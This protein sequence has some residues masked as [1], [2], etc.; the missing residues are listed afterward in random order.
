M[1]ELNGANG[2]SD[3]NGSSTSDAHAE[4]DSELGDQTRPLTHRQSM[5]WTG[6]ALDP[7]VPLYNMAHAFTID[8]ELDIDAFNQAFAALVDGSDALRTVIES[9]AG[10]PVQRVLP[11]TQPE[12]P[13]ID[14]RSSEDSE[15]VVNEWVE[16]RAQLRFDLAAKLYDSVL[17]RTG[18]A[19]YVWYLN[20]HHIVTDAWSVSLMLRRQ[21]ELYEL[22]LDGR[23]A[24]ADPQSAYADFLQAEV[25]DIGSKGHKRAL[26]YW[27]ENLVEQSEPIS[28][29]GHR[30]EDL[31]TETIRVAAEI[32]GERATRLAGFLKDPKIAALSP[33]L[34]ALRFFHTVL[35]A[36]LHRVSGNE[37]V[38]VGTPFH[39]RAKRQTKQTIGL[40]MNLFPVSATIEDNETMTDL[41]AKVGAEIFDG[42]Q[43]ARYPTAVSEQAGAFEVVLNYLH[44][45]YETFGEHAVDD[46]WVHPGAGDRGHSLRLQI[47]R[48]GDDGSFRLFFDVK[49][50]LFD[51]PARQAL[52]QHFL[53][54]IDHWLD[55]ADVPVHAL[56]LL[57]SGGQSQLVEQFNV[58]TGPE[59]TSTTVVDDFERLAAEQPTADAVKGRG[60]ED[61]PSDDALSYGELNRKANR[62][63]HHLAGRN[64]GPGDYVGVL[65]PR[66]PEAIVCILG[67]LKAGAAY[68]PMEPGTPQ[69]R[70]TQMLRDTGAKLVFTERGDVDVVAAAGSAPLIV[71][72]LLADD[73]DAPDTNPTI[74]RSAEHPAYVIFTSGSTGRPKGVSVHHGGL[75]NYISWGR[76]QYTGD[77]SE[78]TGNQAR[79]FALFTSLA[80]DLTITSIFVPLTSGGSI[81]TYPDDTDSGNPSVVQVWRDNT[82]DVVKATPSHLAIVRQLGLV[83]GRLKA[84]IVGGEDFTTDLAGAIQDQHPGLAIYNEYGPTET[85]VGCM[86]H[87]FDR[88]TDRWASVPIGS[89]AA[90]AEILLLDEHCLPVPRGVIGEIYIGGPGVTGGYLQQPEITAE[91][92]V[93]RPETLPQ[94]DRSPVL[95]RS[96]DLG[97]WR[98][99]DGAPQLE[100]LGRADNQVK[101]RGYRI[102]LGEIEAKLTTHQAIESAAV[103]VVSETIGAGLMANPNPASPTTSTEGEIVH[104]EGEIVHCVRCGLPSNFPDATFV[105]DV[106]SLCRDYETYRGKVDDYFGNLD[107]LREVTD[108]IKAKRPADFGAEDYDCVV[109]LSGGKDSTYMLYQVAALGLQPL[110]F[111]LDNG[112][113]SP[114]AL[115]NCRR[116]CDHLG[117]T[118]HVGETEH[119]NEI[120]RDSLDRFSNVCNGCFKTIYTLSMNLARE[121][122]LDYIVTGLAR[123]Q[124]FET[125]LSDMYNHQIFDVDKIDQYV[126]DARKAYHN[127]DDAVTKHLDVS[128]FVDGKIYDEITFVD[129][130]RYADIALDEVM[131]FLA[132]QTPWARP[133]DTGRSTNCLINDVGIHVHN[134]ERGFHNYA[135]P[136]SWDVRLGHKQR[137]AA[138]DELD[139]DIDMDYVNEVLVEIGYKPKPP[140]EQRQTTQLV[141]H[142]QAPAEIADADLRSALATSLPDYMVPTSFV[143]HQLL[144]LTRNGKIDRALLVST[145]RGDD[146]SSANVT[147]IEP[148]HEEAARRLGAIW[149]EI[150]G[151]EIALGDNFFGLGGDSITAI[152]IVDRAASA[153]LTITPR[154]MFEA[155]TLA[156]VATVATWVGAGTASDQD[157]TPTVFELTPTQSGMLFHTLTEPG[158]YEGQIAHHLRGEVDRSALERSWRELIDR[159]PALRTVFGWE[160]V[161]KAEQRI[162]EPGFTETGTPSFSYRELLG[163]PPQQLLEDFLAEDRALGFDLQTTPASR[164]TLLRLANGHVLVWSF[165]HI[166]LDGWSIGLAMNELLDSYQAA[167]DGRPWSPSSRQPFAQYVDWLG[168]QDPAGAEAF[169]RTELADFAAPTALPGSPVAA[170]GSSGQVTTDGRPYAATQRQLSAG[171]TQSLLSYGR[172]Q[173]VTLSTLLQGAWGLVLS[174]YEGSD[175]VVFG[176]TTS[177]RPATLPGAESMVGMMVTT[178]PSRIRISG[179]SEPGAWLRTIQDSQL[180][181]R[182]FEYA[183]LVDVQRWSELGANQS[184]F[185]S[186]LVIENFPDYQPPESD[187]A[188]AI[189]SR[190]YR[191]QSNYP[192][193]LIVLPGPELTIKAVYDPDRFSAAKIDEILSRVENTI[194]MLVSAQPAVLDDVSFT[195]RLEAEQLDLWSSG[196]ALDTDVPGRLPAIPP[197]LLPDMIRSQGQHNPDQIAAVCG[198]EQLTYAQLLA[199][200]SEL[201]DRLRAAG[202]G[203]DVFVGVKLERSLEMVVAIV[204]VMA[205]GGAYLPLDPSYPQQ[206]L[207]FMLDDARAPLVIGDGLTITP[208][209]HQAQLSVPDGQNTTEA[210]AGAR[211]HDLAYLIYTSGSTGQP[212]GVAISHHNLAVSTAA[213]F[214]AYETQPDAFLLLSSFSFDS[215]VVGIF[216]TLATGGKLVLPRSGEELDLR[217]LTDLIERHSVSH[218]LALPSLYRLLLEAAPVS[219]LRSL[220][221]VIVAGEACPAELVTSHFS[222][223]T[224][225]ELY[226]E[227]GPTEATVWC[228]VHRCSANDDGSVPIGSPIPGATVTVLDKTGRFAGIG[229]PGEIYVAGPGVA[230]GY[231]N[232]PELTDERFVEIDGRTW[233]RTRDVGTVEANGLIYFGGRADSQVKIRGFR[234][235]LGEVEAAVRSLSGVGEVVAEVINAG[236]PSGAQLVAFLEASSPVTALSETAVRASLKDR[237]PDVFVPSRVLIVDSLERLPNGKVD[238]SALPVIEAELSGQARRKPNTDAERKIATIWSELLPGV[239]FGADDDFF[240]VGGHSLL[241]VSLVERIRR[242]TGVD[243]PLASLLDTPT[244]A[245]LAKATSSDTTPVDGR[246]LVPLRETGDRV[247]LYL[248]PPAAGTALTFRE[249]VVNAD[250]D[251]P[252]YCFEPLGNDGKHEPHDTVEAMAEHYLEELRVA[253]PDGRFRLAGSCLGAIVAWEMAQRLD[254]AGT[255]AELLVFLDPGPPHSGPGWSYQHP[256]QRSPTEL[257]RSVWEIVA[258]RKVLSAVRA[259]WRRSRFERIGKIHY[260]AQLGYV[261]DRLQV[262]IIWLQSSELAET[263]P[264]F[265]EQWRILAGDDL[266]PIVV[267]ETSHDGLM[268]G[269]ASEVKRMT[270]LMNVALADFDKSDDGPKT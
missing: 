122:G 266:T 230:S 99:G 51:E 14:L 247:P 16:A 77:K 263:Q 129:F 183:S 86:I 265:R 268:T 31:G 109:L 197:T 32:D 208:T 241:A 1:A 159:T 12:L 207:Q 166:A 262:P 213:R 108:Q 242:E 88:D 35:F 200:S 184:L 211:A 139:D 131:S 23:L 85:V 132:E 250:P 123:G 244:I 25:D 84:L 43:H 117:V 202:V 162:L 150:F 253:Q 227:Y 5:I 182:D 116:V 134:R 164:L 198:D 169:W 194:H 143:H 67:I 188:L 149:G 180:A 27:S 17:L 95:Y 206:R 75:N 6:Q 42:M 68:L 248:I 120:F 22:A 44:I 62:V 36:Y 124:L 79:V 115:A 158:M 66:S 91:R 209:E 98:F 125:R 33:E 235:E 146:R 231:H 97:R 55:D 229:V 106:C 155:Q 45:P 267:P 154:Q 101:L 270:K 41:A 90:N 168:Q 232:R 40:F 94:L 107:E 210:G 181:G 221:T 193:S 72:D 261:A 28:F 37:R 157:K 2:D 24:E 53:S 34:T 173:R 83:S 142:Y 54:I 233:F 63:A 179:D 260:R 246:T 145:G 170:T 71:G 59:V 269:M 141:A 252:L 258:E 110:V 251:Q 119:M 255:P 224:S 60:D 89:P 47:R 113:I 178:L 105:D 204:G 225:T 128:A 167:V 195:D 57:D 112:F 196:P 26:A 189:E 186:I 137:D 218:T 203:P 93:P 152:Q 237:L 256:D 153:G 21:S 9:A 219:A 264:R 259:V 96:G 127:I 236:S 104:A 38:V 140:P 147:T 4:P 175:D 243:L 61:A 48:Q 201:A 74:E 7:D 144:P 249:L 103:V 220:K 65:L 187:D 70:L 92:F 126:L 76:R 185:N 19:R 81:I 165:H 156:G 10:T 136:Y 30:P 234:V 3:L 39:N 118:L 148:E 8:I 133:E 102:E 205:A 171:Q 138:L 87:R 254:E 160:G 214:S 18:D 46:R 176:L 121:H 216:W 191:V 245:A 217:I 64:I 239:S 190:A 13:L 80:F 223:L 11:P 212:N 151:Q 29:Y 199:D 177:G 135:L 100:F 215:S 174:R 257:I 56:S 114:S 78:D 50:A 130:Y 192:L 161:D 82:A 111:T 20:Q 15:K 163:E 69:S 49:T 172:D 240:D 58:A 52:V 226:N 73:A 228:T 222:T 238:R